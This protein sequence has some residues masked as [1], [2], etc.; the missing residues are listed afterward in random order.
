MSNG[1]RVL[2]SFE[3]APV[4]KVGLKPQTKASDPLFMTIEGSGF[5]KAVSVRLDGVHISG[6]MVIND[7][8]IVLEVPEAMYFTPISQVDVLTET[9]AAS[10]AVRVTYAIGSP[11]SIRGVLKLAQRVTKLLMTTPGS[12]IFHPSDGGGIL[13]IL[14]QAVHQTSASGV[15]AQVMVGIDRVSKRLIEDQAARRLP[16]DERLAQIHILELRFDQSSGTL[17]VRLG[18]ETMTGTFAVTGLEA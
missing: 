14:G 2:Q 1:L 15:S 10:Q 18:V 12:D 6:F 13:S 3:I 5:D 17:N 4:R 7:S 16:G 11:K 9:E 8:S